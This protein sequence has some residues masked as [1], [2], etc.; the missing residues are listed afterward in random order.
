MELE[1][2]SIQLAG[3]GGVIADVDEGRNVQVFQAIPGYP[4]AGGFYSVTGQASAVVAASLAA[5]TPL[6][7]MRFSAGSARK[8]YILRARIAMIAATAGAAGG[9]A[10]GLALQRFTT[11][12]PTGG[13]ARTPAPASLTK[14]SATDMTDVRD[15]NAALTVTSVVF[16]AIVASTIIP[17]G[18]TNVAPFE[19]QVDF[20]API[21]LSAGD[22]LSL[23]T[24]VAGPATAT[25]TYSYNFYWVE[26]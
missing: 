24:S 26:R 1:L 15:S 6:M 3:N 2:M 8:A 10:G 9:I 7:T 19:W 20:P 13:T 11:A 5:N 4:A 18:S 14:G 25:W 12:T 23:R 22:G 21:E 16:T 17:V